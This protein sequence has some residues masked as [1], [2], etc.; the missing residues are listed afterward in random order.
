MIASPRA[1]ACDDWRTYAAD[2]IAP[3]IDAEAQAWRRELGWDVTESWQPVANARAVGA[4]PGFVTRDAAGTIT[5]W[6]WFLEH[7]G[8]LQ[9]GALVAATAA[10]AHALVDAI[11]TSA[12]ASRTRQMILCLRDPGAAVIEA[13]AARDIEITRYLY[14]ST[15]TTSVALPMTRSQERPW[16]D[17]DADSVAA[18]C[19]RA[20]ARTDEVRAFA[21]N[22]TSDEWREYIGSLV[23]TPACG[24]FLPAAS[25]IVSAQGTAIAAVMV[26]A[27]DARVAHLAQVVVDPQTQRQGYGR[28]LVGIALAEVQQ[29]GFSRATLLVAEGNL[30]ARRLYDALGFRDHSVFV[31]ARTRVSRAG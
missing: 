16:R 22:G 11:V 10:A 23:R 3:L 20:Y 14:L 31:V 6:T 4:L 17:G 30:P 29:R 2:A 18:L 27:I 19:A 21:P 25:V 13:L 5:G 1:V 15:P 24:R 7:R 12:S 8:T 28:H 26:T 9:V